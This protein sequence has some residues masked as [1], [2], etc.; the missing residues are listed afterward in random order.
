MEA[1]EMVMKME[2]VM[3]MMIA[4]EMVLVMAMAMRIPP[5]NSQTPDCTNLMKRLLSS[6]DKRSYQKWK[7]ELHS[8]TCQEVMIWRWGW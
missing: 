4:A 2:M 1:M 8:N 3:V 5:T 7:K 6:L